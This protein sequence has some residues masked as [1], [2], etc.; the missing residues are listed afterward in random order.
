MFMKKQ[1]LL[2]LLLSLC[3]ASCAR[4]FPK[5]TEH[6][7]FGH[8]SEAEAAFNKG[9]Y[10]E[11]LDKYSAYIAENPEGSLAVIAKYYMAKSHANL[12]Q[13]D[14]ARPL[15]QEIMTKHPDLV[16]AKFSESQLKDLDQAGSAPKAT[17]LASS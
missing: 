12:G 17:A 9:N 7:Y 3:L 6:F 8:Y 13:P 10:Q 16:W 14:K 11:A 2:V 1:T 15:Y 4:W 5:G